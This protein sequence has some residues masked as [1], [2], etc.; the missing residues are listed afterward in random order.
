MTQAEE[1]PAEL[2]QEVEKTSGE[3]SDESIANQKLTAQIEVKAKLRC[4][5]LSEITDLFKFIF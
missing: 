3:E 5:H 2:K 1:K 4:I